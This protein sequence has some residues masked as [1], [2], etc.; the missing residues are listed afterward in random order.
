M[1]M[2][3]R[4]IIMSI[5]GL[6]SPPPNLPLKKGE[7]QIAFVMTLVSHGTVPP[8]SRGRLGGG[9]VGKETAHVR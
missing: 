2:S 1:D 4:G 8:P 3:M 5:E 9:Y 7:E 6:N